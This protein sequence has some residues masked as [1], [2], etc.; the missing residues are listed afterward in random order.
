MKKRI[1]ITIIDTREC[2]PDDWSLVWYRDWAITTKSNEALLMQHAAAIDNAIANHA[3]KVKPLLKKFA[4]NCSE[5]DREYE[6][7]DF[8]SLK[9]NFKVTTYSAE[10]IGHMTDSDFNICRSSSMGAI[11]IGNNATC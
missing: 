8:D 9:V 6:V 1:E 10:G 7:T 11:A 5:Y 2:I 4:D 3:E